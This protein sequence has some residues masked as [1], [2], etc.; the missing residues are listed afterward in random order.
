VEPGKD[1]RNNP[2]IYDAL[3]R[4]ELSKNPETDCNWHYVASADNGTALPTK[5]GLPFLL[6]F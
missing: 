5:I 2:G 6:Y 3:R 1:L 4:G